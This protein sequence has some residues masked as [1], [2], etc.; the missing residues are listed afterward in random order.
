MTIPPNP[1]PEQVEITQEDRNIAHE[2]RF[3]Q[4]GYTVRMGDGHHLVQAFARHRL[5]SLAN[6]PADDGERKAAVVQ[7]A[8]A[9]SALSVALDG[10]G[11]VKEREAVLAGL[12]AVRDAG[13]LLPQ[14]EGVKRP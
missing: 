13:C 11:W 10:R 5:A 1:H 9:A 8:E 7:L 3:Q 6:R 12:K 14:P 4:L 2:T